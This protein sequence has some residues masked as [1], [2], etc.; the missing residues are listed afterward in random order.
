M[1]DRL[2]RL[3][4]WSLRLRLIVEDL[5]CERGGRRL[6]AN[7]GFHVESGEALALTGRNGA[8]KSSLLAILAGLLAP[9]SGR[10]LLNSGDPDREIGEQAH[11]VGHRDSLKAA[12]TP[13]EML[14]F[15]QS[16]LGSSLQTPEDALEE[17]GLAHVGELPCGYLS[18]GQRRRV[19][20]ARLLVAH[21][22]IWLLDEP[23]SALDTR[24]QGRIAKLMQAHL[25]A[26]GL[27]LAATHGPLGLG[28]AKELRIGDGL[29][30]QDAGS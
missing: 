23:T 27:I 22:P 4:N 1:F 9:T 24:S 13:L 19:S 18:A 20:L 17:I 6:F 26:G 12:M 7:M 11:L 10:I 28:V 15:W 8:G 5:A 29:L 25:D 21:R 30:A 14:G 3:A 16:T 2:N